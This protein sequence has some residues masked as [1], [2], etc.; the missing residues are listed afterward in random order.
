MKKNLTTTVS[1]ESFKEIWK[2]IDLTVA[3]WHVN[4]L[5]NDK[6]GYTRSTRLKQ[7]IG[8]ESKEAKMVKHAAYAWFQY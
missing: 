1:N 3:E 7:P 6:T 8:T 2:E 5:A 4:F